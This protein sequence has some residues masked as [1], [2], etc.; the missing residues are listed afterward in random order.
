MAWILRNCGNE[1]R[2]TRLER[3]APTKNTDVHL[4]TM[5]ITENKGEEPDEARYDRMES[6]SERKHQ[7]RILGYCRKWNITPHHNK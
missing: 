2:N 3:M 4:E 6:V 5:E 7:E 1:E